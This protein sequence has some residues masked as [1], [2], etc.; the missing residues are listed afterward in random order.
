MIPGMQGIGKI[1]ELRK[2][3][4]FTL[5]MLA[6]YRFGVFVST[7]G[8]DVEALRQQFATGDGTLFGLVNMFSGGALEQFS[9]FTLGIMPYISVSIIMQLLTSS[10]PALEALKKDGEAGQRVI[11]RYTRQGTVVLALFQGFMIAVGLEGQGLVLSPGWMFRITT[12]ITLTAGTSFIMWLGEQINEKGIGNGMSIV[13]FAGIVARMPQTFVSTLVLARSQEVAPLTILIVI[14]FCIATVAGIVFVERSH[15]K[16]PIQYPRRM[17]GKKMSQ[18]QTQ[19]MPLKVNMAGVI[20]PIFASAFLLLPATVASVTTNET[21]AEMMQYLVPGSWVYTV[22]FAGLIIFFAFFY[23][24]MI[25]NPPE[26][27][28]NLKKNGGFVPTVRPG[29]ATADFLYGVLNRLTLWGSIYIAAI[30]LIPQIFYMKMGLTTFAYIFG[31]TSILIAVGVILDTV[32][33]IESHIVARN[34]E[35]FMGKTSKAK[36]GVGSMG[37]SRSRLLRR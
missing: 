35:E 36:G 28:E 3:I 27:A 34:Y 25:F 20:P 9:I 33:Q 21:L 23:T 7:P 22:I 13:I 37:Y 17:V 15:R 6:V 24:A 12:M 2:R 30:C 29:K 26:V 8:I 16:I 32:S 5:W 11:T 31:G 10:I 14:A 18:A 19:H 1:P 4:F